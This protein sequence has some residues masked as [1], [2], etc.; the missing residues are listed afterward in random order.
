[1]VKFKR[2]QLS[3]RGQKA[4]IWKDPGGGQDVLRQRNICASAGIQTAT[5]LSNSLQSAGHRSYL[6][7]E[8]LFV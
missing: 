2:R 4:G 8:L 1:M 5:A 3:R 7:I 6:L